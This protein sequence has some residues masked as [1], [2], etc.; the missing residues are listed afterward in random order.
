MYRHRRGFRLA[1]STTVP[2]TPLDVS[3]TV[4]ATPLD[5]G[6]ELAS[7]RA[8]VAAG[9]PHPS[10]TDGSCVTPTPGGGKLR[11]YCRT[12]GSALDVVGPF[13]NETS[14]LASSRER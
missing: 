7:A 4:P 8:G 11:P 9:R 10:H 6:A 1:V 3:T 14:L 12:V 2:A 13:E 5:V